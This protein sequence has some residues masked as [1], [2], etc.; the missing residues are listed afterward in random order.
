MNLFKAA[1]T[2]TWPTHAPVAGRAI[3]LTFAEVLRT[4]LAVDAAGPAPCSLQVPQ[5]LTPAIGAMQTAY[6][7]AAGRT[8]PDFTE[9]GA[10]NISGMTLTPGL[11][12]W[13]TG[14]SADNTG[15][16]LSGGPNAVWIFQ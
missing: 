7:D 12:K 4:I 11:Y 1:R 9:L 3:P 2:V 6:T 15:F 5:L 8:I 16:T 10:G 14:V 13:S